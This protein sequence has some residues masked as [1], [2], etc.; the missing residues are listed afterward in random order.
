M[1]EFEISIANQA[2][3]ALVSDMVLTSDLTD[4]HFQSNCS[5]TH[6][7]NYNLFQA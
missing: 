1:H 2:V 3:H 7:L 6:L 4:H 5:T